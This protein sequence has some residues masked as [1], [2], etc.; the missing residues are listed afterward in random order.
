MNRLF[1]LLLCL[2]WMGLNCPTVLIA[3]ERRADVPASIHDALRLTKQA[4]ISGAGQ[5]RER[6][7]AQTDRALQ[8]ALEASKR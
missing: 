6:F 4:E 5:D 3:A 8:A 7:V 2:G 1:C